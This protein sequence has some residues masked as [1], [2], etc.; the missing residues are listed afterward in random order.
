MRLA[1][2]QALD[3]L[4]HI[5]TNREDRGLVP[6]CFERRGN[7]LHDDVGFLVARLEISQD[8]NIHR[9]AWQLARVALLVRALRIRANAWT[10]KHF[11]LDAKWKRATIP[12][13][14]REQLGQC[15]RSS[16]D[17]DNEQRLPRCG[18]RSPERARA[19]SPSSRDVHGHDAPESPRP[20]GHRQQRRR[21]AVRP[22][23]EDRRGAIRGRLAR[24]SRRRPRNAGRHPSAGKAVRRRVDPHAIARGREVQRQELSIRGWPARRRRVG[25]ERA[26]EEPRGLD[27]AR[28][29]GIQHE[30]RERQSPQQARGRRQGRQGQHGH[31]GTLLAR[32]EVLRQRAVLA[33]E[34]EAR[35]ARE[36]GAL[37]RPRGHARGREAEGEGALGLHGGAQSST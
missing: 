8:R 16:A 31:D 6:R 23:E 33:P 4:D 24:S 7:L 11:R 36:G 5:V 30:L 19:R 13:G 35:A 10:A 20:R 32:S 22:R 18:H 3:H 34:A 37:P 29:Q 15:G 2:L 1:L 26:L 9:S 27:P 25:R 28:R 21:G 14:S 17:P 12:R